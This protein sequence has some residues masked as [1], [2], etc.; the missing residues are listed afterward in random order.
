MA[1]GGDVKLIPPGL[2]PDSGDHDN[3]ASWAG[4]I[5]FVL[6]CSIAIALPTTLVIMVLTPN[7]VDQQLE[8]VITTIASSAVGALASYLGFARGTAAGHR[9][10]DEDDSGPAAPPPTGPAGPP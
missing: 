3:A 2:L 6:A 4:P 7:P 10:R 8:A 9:D 5:A 1:G